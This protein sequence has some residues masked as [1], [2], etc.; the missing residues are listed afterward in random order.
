MTDNGITVG[1]WGT[2]QIKRF[3]DAS[4]QNLYMSSWSGAK[5]IPYSKYSIKESDMRVKT[6]NFTSPQYLDLTFKQNASTINEIVV[7]KEKKNISSTSCE[8]NGNE[9]KILNCTFDSLVQYSEEDQGDYNISYKDECGNLQQ[10][11]GI[12]VELIYLNY[13]I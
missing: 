2:I 3:S 11:D 9:D 8:H 13:F 4:K 10:I 1:D 6:A 5:N 12:K 7:V